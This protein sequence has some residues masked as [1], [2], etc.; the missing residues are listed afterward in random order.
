VRNGTVD[1]AIA[2]CSRLLA[3]DPKD[4]LAYAGRGIAYN[5]KGNYDRA[6]SDFDQAIRPGFAFASHDKTIWQGCE[7]LVAHSCG[8]DIHVT[9]RV[10]TAETLVGLKD[11]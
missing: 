6:I 10:G 3:A 7:T 4:A 9:S 1:E 8:H 11:Q 2:A 5:R